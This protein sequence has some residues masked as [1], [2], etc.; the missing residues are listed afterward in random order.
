VCFTL[1]VVFLSL[2]TVIPVFHVATE[3]LD[4]GDRLIESLLQSKV[5]QNA[6][7]SLGPIPERAGEAL[8]RL[9]LRRKH[10]VV[11]VCVLWRARG[12]GVCGSAGRGVR[13]R[14]AVPG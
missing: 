6:S 2:V 14:R 7:E 13:A 10:P 11:I 1:L 12:G 5:V 4:P 8:Y 3:G 9:G